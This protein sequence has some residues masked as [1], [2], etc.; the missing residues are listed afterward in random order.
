M[1]AEQ[2]RSSSKKTIS[3]RGLKVIRTHCLDCCAK[4][5]KGVEMC[6]AVTCAL[7]PHRFGMRPITAH[8]KGKNVI[9]PGCTEDD[10]D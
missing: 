10:L 9:P 3:M 7:W 4:S 1:A 8:K 5:Y 2:R 6:G